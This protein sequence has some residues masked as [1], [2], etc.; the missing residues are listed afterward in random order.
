M[1]A[2]PATLRGLDHRDLLRWLLDLPPAD[3]ERLHDCIERVRPL[4]GDGVRDPANTGNQ[5][6]ARQPDP[7]ERVR[8]LDTHAE[9]RPPCF[10]MKH[11][12]SYCAL[13]PCGR[14]TLCRLHPGRCSC[15]HCHKAYK[16]GLPKGNGK[17]SYYR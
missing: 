10:E 15:N 5:G 9:E 11:L 1:N 16:Q 17:G 7:G 6:A 14:K 4:E 2:L 12:C 13:N 8:P 3:L